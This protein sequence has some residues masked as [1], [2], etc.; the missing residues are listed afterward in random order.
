VHEGDAQPGSGI[1]RPPVDN[2]CYN[3]YIGR[4]SGVAEEIKQRKPFS[5]REEEAFLALQRTADQLQWR[6]A[7]M[8]RPHG[9]SPTQYNALRILRGA[10][11][12]GL[13]CSEIGERMVNRDPDITRLLDRLEKR[14]L[15]T[16][17]RC[18]KDRRVVTATLT[19]QGR[20]LLGTLDRP[21][22]EFARSLLGHLG[23]GRLA[24]LIE[25]LADARAR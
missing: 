25:L 10:G 5:S 20:K 6:A 8:L 21:V 1:G 15:V 7:E 16:R 14:G 9:L 24:A 11:A 13:A 22:E 12:E 23:K 19:P 2:S 4:V 17:S 18:Q 3:D